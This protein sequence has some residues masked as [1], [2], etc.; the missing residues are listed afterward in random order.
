MASARALLSLPLPQTVHLGLGSHHAHPPTSLHSTPPPP[1][2]LASILRPLAAESPPQACALYED[3]KSATGRAPPSTACAAVLPL[4]ESAGRWQDAVAVPQV[5]PSAE[6]FSR[7]LELECRV[8][9]W[10]RL[11]ES[12][13]SVRWA[14]RRE[15]A[16]HRWRDEVLA[17]SGS[18]SGSGS[19]SAGAE[20][21]VAQGSDASLLS[22]L[23]SVL[24]L[25]TEPDAQQGRLEASLL[26][27]LRRGRSLPRGVA[28]KI[29][30]RQVGSEGLL[31][32]RALLLRASTSGVRLDSGAYSAL[33]CAHAAMGC[34]EQSVEIALQAIERGVHLSPSA[35]LAALAAVR[36]PDDL[37]TISS[38]MGR[39]PRLHWFRVYSDWAV[40]NVLAVAG[41][42]GIGGEGRRQP[43]LVAAT[44]EEIYLA[45][46]VRCARAARTHTHCIAGPMRAHTHTALQV[47]CARTHTAC[48]CPTTAWLSLSLS[49]SRA[50]T[51]SLVQTLARASPIALS[52]DSS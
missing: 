43:A 44:E 21:G 50:R 15:A 38:A 27:A 8:E 2:P 47:R 10:L 36:T 14:G 48:C 46:Q 23:R 24:Q 31:R 16:I 17:A 29:A 1:A 18:G 49:L 20:G 34:N 3:F 32:A 42:L 30:Y 35:F 19:G 28:A 13:R 7:A 45:L 51:H 5:V 4:Y 11:A 41:A 37:R 52:D 12:E 25:P 9:S 33:C 39:A 6:A 40:S 26:T 22:A